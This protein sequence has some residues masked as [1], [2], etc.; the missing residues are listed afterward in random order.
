[1]MAFAAI[2]MTAIVAV[3]AFAIDVGS[4]Y[5][6]SRQAEAAADAGATAAA[7][8]LPGSPA[9]AVTDAQTYVNKNISGAT[10]TTVTPYGGDSSKIQVTVHATAPSYFA[11]IF[12]INS[13]SVTES[14]IAKRVS[15]LCAPVLSSSL[16]AIV[17]SDETLEPV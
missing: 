9:T 2:S 3:A 15:E 11:K 6:V 7:T 13:V 16:D 1:M 12:G 14:A 5:K 17:V 4:W 10:T 8:D